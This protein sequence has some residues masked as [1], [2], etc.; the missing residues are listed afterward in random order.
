M[1]RSATKRTVISLRGLSKSFPGQVALRDV[2][3]DV[4]AGEVHALVGENGSGKSTLIKCLSGYHTPDAGSEMDFVG[5]PGGKGAARG[6]LAFV[7]QDIGVVPTL[8]VA[9]NIALGR[10]FAARG[11]LHISWHRQREI[12]RRAL[13]RLGRDDIDPS[14]EAGSLSPA[15]QTII[16]LAR[17]FDSL[18]DGG[19]IV[20][21]E[22][23][24][25][26][27]ESDVETLFET[28][29]EVVS[30]GVGVLFVSHR[31]GEVLQLADRVTVLREGVNQGTFAVGDLDERQLVSLI[32]G[33]P[34]ESMYADTAASPARDV[35]LEVAALT[36][37]RLTDVSFSLR[38]GEILGVAGLL[39]AGKSELLRLLFGAQAKAGGTVTTGGTDL[40]NAG[41][42]E[43][44]HAGLAYVSPDR[45]RCSV[46]G[47]MSIAENL[48]LCTLRRYGTA[49][50]RRGEE[51]RRV[52]HLIKEFHIQPPT[53]SRLVA[54]LSG[55]NQQKVVLA[56]A[57]E[58]DPKVLLLDEPTQGVDIGAKAEIHRIVEDRASQGTGIVLVS[59]ENE[60]LAALC[61]R[62]L[63]LRSGVVAAELR[64]PELTV[65]A[66]HHWSYLQGEAA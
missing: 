20:M 58:T 28:I 37:P 24:A 41:P 50:I 7:H 54:H 29:R 43:C 64:P 18:T 52:R 9:E 12:A 27:A 25:A 14:A 33:R 49:H 56:R 32:L 45:L 13:H 2:N 6:A 39:G 17:A 61:H 5:S 53:P 38:H 26:L 22:P 55:G 62:V 35:V 47:Q 42:H 1:S 57:I 4:R 63:V 65:D 11:G 10:G 48:T 60:D 31:L 46:L 34:L 59:S 51:L 44:L 23:T 3:L 36:G 66:I 16:A 8:T 19:A 15:R 21:D 40:T 30:Q